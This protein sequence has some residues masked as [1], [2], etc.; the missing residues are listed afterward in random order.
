MTVEI[1]RLVTRFETDITD[2]KR[3]MREISRHSRETTAKMGKD[4]RVVASKIRGVFGGVLAA[5]GGTALTQGLLDVNIQFE[6]LEARLRTLTRGDAKEAA[7][8]FNTLV[9][10]AGELPFSIDQTV[11]AFARLGLLGLKPSTDAIKSFANIA[12]A[13][14]SQGAQ[15]LKQV[16]E[17]V[18]DAT[19]M[20]FE[21]LKELGIVARKEGESVNITFRGTTRTVKATAKEITAFFEQ[22]GT[23]EFAGAAEERMKGL[24][25]SLSNLGDAFKRAAK[26]IGESG[27]NAAIKSTADA[28]APL[29]EPATGYAINAVKSL[30]SAFKDFASI[31]SDVFGAVIDAFGKGDTLSR[32]PSPAPR[33]GVIRGVPGDVRGVGSSLR[34]EGGT[35]S[36][37]K[38]EEKNSMKTLR[39]LQSIDGKLSFT[40]LGAVMQ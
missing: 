23:V 7:R 39:T 35:I 9:D 20:E 40:N 31:P 11:D 2:I 32:I 22:L 1:E 17:A 5:A 15:S 13:V 3:D 34:Q 36:G 19:T 37:A 28:I 25:G 18:A 38:I 29:V 4:F 8:I 16:V 27:F 10:V 6:Q 33:T 21:R 30:T 26:L 14:G 12:S 24:E